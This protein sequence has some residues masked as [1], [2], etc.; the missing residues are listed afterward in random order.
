VFDEAVPRADRT[1]IPA[2]F[3]GLGLFL[4]LFVGVG[5]YNVVVDVP[6]SSW[7]TFWHGYVYVM[8]GAGSA[9]L[10][11]I[12]VGGFRDVRRLVVMLGNGEKPL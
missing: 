2:L 5:L 4:V 7:T 9:F 3:A 1:L 11:W 12:S 8:F 6:V 10:V